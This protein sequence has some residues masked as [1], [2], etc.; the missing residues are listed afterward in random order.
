MNSSYKGIRSNLKFS[1]KTVK[2]LS[3]LTKLELSI[4]GKS[5]SDGQTDLLS[6]SSSLVGWLYGEEVSSL[7][8]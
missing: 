2:T 6:S 5:K 3:C 8:K 1:F 4:G 7:V